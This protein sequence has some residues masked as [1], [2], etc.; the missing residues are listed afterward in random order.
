LR[1][2]FSATVVAVHSFGTGNDANVPCSAGSVLTG[3]GFQSAMAPVVFS[4]PDGNGWKVEQQ[5]LNQGN[6]NPTV[7]ALCATQG[8]Q[9]ALLQQA[10]VPVAANQN[11]T[12]GAKCPQGQLPVGGGFNGYAPSVDVSW[13]V[14][15]SEPNFIGQG[16]TI[17]SG[18]AAA[19]QNL[20]QVSETFTV[21]EVCDTH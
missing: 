20:E 5:F 16:S 2:N 4:Q 10:S 7:Y 11:G 3:G 21:Y 19:V 13:T 14:W 18:W 8:L 9:A 6:G 12:N 15:Q 1:A 17:S